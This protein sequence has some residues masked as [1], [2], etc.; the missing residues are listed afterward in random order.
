MGHAQC[1]V[2]AV[3]I[4]NVGILYARP[5]MASSKTK[6]PTPHAK[7]DVTIWKYSKKKP[8]VLA[9]WTASRGG[10]YSD[11]DIDSQASGLANGAAQAGPSYAT[12]YRMET[13][14]R[15]LEI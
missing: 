13:L 6:P 10:L 3:L 15:A 1:K 11:H 14:L 8:P 4:H 2:I 9:E 12:N 5:L 7:E